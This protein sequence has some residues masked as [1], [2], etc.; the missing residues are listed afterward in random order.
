MILGEGQNGNSDS[1]TDGANNTQGL[2]R[3]FSTPSRYKS[4][5][6][7]KESHEGQDADSWLLVTGSAYATGPRCTFPQ[8]SRP[9]RR[10]AICGTI[11]TIEDD[12]W[13]HMK[14]AHGQARTHQ[15]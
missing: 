10:C 8:V 2:H 12:Y 13:E 15:F 6:E 11:F 1:D 4:H 14:T 5:F 9:Q 3:S 7:N